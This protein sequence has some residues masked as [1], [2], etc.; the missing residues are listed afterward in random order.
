MGWWQRFT[1]DRTWTGLGQVLFQGHPCVVLRQHRDK[2]GLEADEKSPTW[3]GGEGHRARKTGSMCV[4]RWKD[5]ND[6]A[7]RARRSTGK[8]GGKREESIDTRRILSGKDG[9][10]GGRKGRGPLGRR[11]VEFRNGRSGEG[12]KVGDGGWRETWREGGRE[13]RNGRET[14]EVLQDIVTRMRRDWEEYSKC[15]QA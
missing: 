15:Q 7:A 13:E 4:E 12:S 10:K 5:R 8:D 2:R 3:E 1:K 14:P 9:G 11:E 6:G